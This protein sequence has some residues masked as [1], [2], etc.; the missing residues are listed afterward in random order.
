MMDPKLLEI[1]T[2]AKTLQVEPRIIALLR[3]A[4]NAG[5]SKNWQNEY[6]RGWLEALDKAESMIFELKQ[7]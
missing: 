1:L 4:Y 7:R 2:E 6:D 3:L 5:V